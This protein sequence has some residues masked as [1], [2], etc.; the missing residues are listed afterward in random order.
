MNFTFFLFLLLVNTGINYS[1]GQ[2]TF[3]NPV[4]SGDAPDPFVMYK[5]GFYYGCHTTGGTNVQIYKSRSL[6]TIFNTKSAHQQMRAESANHYWRKN[7][8]LNSHL[9]EKRHTGCTTSFYRAGWKMNIKIFFYFYFH[10]S[11]KRD[12]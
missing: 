1:A 2:C 6:Q 9:K 10:V 3:K 4:K 11:N 8:C 7:Y 5:D 12:R